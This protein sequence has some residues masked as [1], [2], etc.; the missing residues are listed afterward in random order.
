MSAHIIYIMYDLSYQSYGSRKEITCI[1]MYTREREVS[2][3]SS[4]IDGR[5][6]DL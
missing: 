1:S 6:L 5:E 2:F 3:Y 4:A